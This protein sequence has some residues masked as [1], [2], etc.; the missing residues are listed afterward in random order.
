MTKSK[1]ILPQSDD[2]FWRRCPLSQKHHKH[3]MMWQLPW[4]LIIFYWTTRISTIASQTQAYLGKKVKISWG[5]INMRSYN[6]SFFFFFFQ[7]VF[8]NVLNTNILDHE[9]EDVCYFFIWPLPLP[10][11]SSWHCCATDESWPLELQWAA[12]A[13]VLHWN[14]WFHILRRCPSKEWKVDNLADRRTWQGKR[15]R[16]GPWKHHSLEVCGINLIHNNSTMKNLIL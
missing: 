3:D 5:I 15:S 10:K 4:Q 2:F 6:F 12:S 11:I 13:L 8:W 14:W 9:S 7:R 1:D 16:W